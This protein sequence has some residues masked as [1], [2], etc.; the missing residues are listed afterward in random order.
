MSLFFVEEKILRGFP[1]I[2]FFF[3]LA[4]PPIFD[5]CTK[6][7]EAHAELKARDL[8]WQAASGEN[9]DIKEAVKL[10]EQA[11]ELNPFAGEFHIVLAHCFLIES[12]F[13]EAL[14]EAQRGVKLLVE[15]GTSYDK[16]KDWAAWV[17]WG[18]VLAMHGKN[19]TWAT[20]SW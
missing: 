7:L 2:F 6:I 17:A 14:N 4:V 15:W 12:R 20:N 16:R 19:K 10:L 1:A 13:E 5:N 9:H 8:Y 18:R 11:I 3:L